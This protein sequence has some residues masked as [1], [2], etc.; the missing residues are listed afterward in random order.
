MLSRKIVCLLG[1]ASALFA[2]PDWKPSYEDK[3]VTAAESA[4]IDAALPSQLIAPVSQPRRVLVF[5]ATAAFRHSSI[6]VGKEALTK[7]GKATGA[8]ETVI[9]DDPAN[10][11]FDVLK[12]FDSVLL[13]S[14]TRDFFMPH[15][16]QRDQ[17]TAEQWHALQLRHNRLVDNL[18]AY[19]EQ[20]GGLVGIHSATDG[21]YGHQKFGEMMGGY[22]NGH[23]WNAHNRVVVAVEDPEHEVIQPVFGDRE[24]FEIKEEIYQFRDVPYSRDRLRILLHVDVEKSDKVEGLKRADGD[25]PVAWVQSVGQGRVF[26]SSIGHNHNMYSNPLVLKH[27]LAG[28][29]FACGDL[30]ADTRPSAPISMPHVSR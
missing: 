30:K 11:E 7:L 10:F 24:S 21:C 8:F 20:G 6:P 19:V 23:P 5:S 3:P 29:Q 9:S 1:C 25:Y 14:S 15:N 26:Y 2:E 27:Y 22:F 28:I 13:L 12:T 17:F 4:A 16:R 18:V